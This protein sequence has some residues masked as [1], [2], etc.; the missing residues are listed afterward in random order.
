MSEREIDKEE[1]THGMKINSSCKKCQG[2]FK[3]EDTI[4]LFKQHQ[5]HFNCFICANCR[6]PLS[7]ESFYLDEKLQLDVGTIS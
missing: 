6:K 3:H 4:A 2:Y 1:E 7:H 5:Y